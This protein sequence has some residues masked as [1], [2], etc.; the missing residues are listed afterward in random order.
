ML[1]R[2]LRSIFLSTIRRRVGEPDDP[3]KVDVEGARYILGYHGELVTNVE[4]RA[5]AH[6][7]RTRTMTYEDWETLQPD[8]REQMTQKY[9]PAL[10]TDPAVLK[11]LEDDYDAFA[12]RTAS[13]SVEEH[14]DH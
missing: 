6:W 3:F 12:V 4:H 8:F 11:L 10:S 13:R 2:R 14:S 7:S 5:S 9:S 1:A